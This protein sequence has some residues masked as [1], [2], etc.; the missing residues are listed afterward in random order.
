[1]PI[2]SARVEP[3]SNG[4]HWSY[5][6]HPA[7][8]IICGAGIPTAYAKNLPPDRA[9]H[10][11]PPVMLSLGV[12]LRRSQNSGASGEALSRKFLLDFHTFH[13]MGRP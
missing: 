2:A 11:W 7:A 4:S 9:P 13:G 3:S 8:P 5:P 12:R 10:R 1:M 6:T